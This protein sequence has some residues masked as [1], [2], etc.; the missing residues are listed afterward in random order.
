MGSCR[1]AT[2]L[3]YVLCAFK[4]MLS[5]CCSTDH[6]WLALPVSCFVVTAHRV[7]F[8]ILHVCISWL[9]TQADYK[10]PMFSV[11]WT[12]RICQGLCRDLDL[13][14][15][16]CHHDVTR[17]P[18]Y[19]GS[20]WPRAGLTFDRGLWLTFCVI[21]LSSVAR[22]TCFCLTTKNKQGQY[23]ECVNHRNKI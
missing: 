14:V 9:W 21:A 10:F 6:D 13:R 19:L 18:P 8:I 22:T 7:L 12:Y 4:I 5:I 17:W 1:P 11:G 23:A 2:C 20:L 15:A 16:G 3:M